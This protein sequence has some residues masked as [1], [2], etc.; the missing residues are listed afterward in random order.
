MSARVDGGAQVYSLLSLPSSKAMQIA[1]ANQFDYQEIAFIEFSDGAS[2]FIFPELMNSNVILFLEFNKPM[3]LFAFRALKMIEY[4]KKHANL[5]CIIA[6]FMPFLR[7][8]NANIDSLQLFQGYKIITIDAHVQKP[9]IIS[10]Q[11]TM[12]QNAIGAQ[13][14]LVL[15]DDGAKRYLKCFAQNEYCIG[16]KN[17]ERGIVFADGA[18]FANRDCVI[19]DDIVA[20]G[21][22]LKLAIAEIATHNPKSIKAFVTHNLLAENIVMPHLAYFGVSDTLVSNIDAVLFDYAPVFFDLRRC[23]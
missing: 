15:P 1:Q 23:L 6:P 7:E 21:T 17:R 14:L 19:I 3:D 12:F 20:T 16:V 8:K 13:D 5:V 9:N 10:L 4:I 22:T 18:K 11:P 2:D